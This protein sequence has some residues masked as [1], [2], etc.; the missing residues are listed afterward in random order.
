MKLNQFADYK[1]QRWEE[2]QMR[3]FKLN[4]RVLRLDQLQTS[5]FEFLN[6]LKNIVVTFL[7]ATLVIKGNLT[8][9]VMMSISY[10]IG[11]MNSPV[12]Q[13]IGFIRGLQDT[14]LSLER[15]NEVQNHPE[16]EQAGQLK[17][18]HSNNQLILLW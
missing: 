15:L 8:L 1:R 18:I 3:L 10:I 17:M 13:L 7:A 4:I 14:K 9:G 6:Q 12:N 5:G 16:E 11:Q 2:I